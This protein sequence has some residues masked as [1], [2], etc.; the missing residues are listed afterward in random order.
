[1]GGIAAAH[2]VLALPRPQQPD[3]LRLLNGYQVKA[4][5]SA[6]SFIWWEIHQTCG[7]RDNLK[8]RM[9]LLMEAAGGYV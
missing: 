8:M 3:D 5:Y 1:M 2:C 9:I 7:E 6:M 4:P